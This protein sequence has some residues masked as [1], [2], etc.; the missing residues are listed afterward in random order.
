M[1]TAKSI[2][3]NEESSDASPNEKSSGNENDK[4][5]STFSGRKAKYPFPYYGGFF[6]EAARRQKVA[7]LGEAFESIIG[8]N[9]NLNPAY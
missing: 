5:P 2:A 6:S 3:I 7:Q 4:S 9:K 8:K 1:R